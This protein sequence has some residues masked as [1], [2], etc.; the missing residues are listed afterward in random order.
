MFLVCVCR[1][2]WR[3]I[4]IRFIVLSAGVFARNLENPERTS[5]GPAIE[6]QSKK[7]DFFS[8][9][10]FTAAEVNLFYARR[11]KNLVP[12]SNY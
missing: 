9:T 12:V 8:G 4:F 3:V 6:Q 2:I 7:F 11:E 1:L 10:K 5:F